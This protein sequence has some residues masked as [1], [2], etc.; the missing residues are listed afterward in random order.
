MS[1]C[2]DPPQPPPVPQ[3]LHP[4]QP[5]VIKSRTGD[6]SLPSKYLATS[7]WAAWVTVIMFISFNLLEFTDPFP[8][9]S[10]K[11]IQFFGRPQSTDICDHLPGH[12][13]E[14]ASLS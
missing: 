10:F 1:S 5:D 7:S 12:I 9:K 4:P 3:E 13:G 2:Y 8:G 14:L 6:F 11:S